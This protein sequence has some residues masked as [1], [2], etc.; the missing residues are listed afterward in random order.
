MPVVTRLVLPFSIFWLAFTWFICC[1]PRFGS[2][3]LIS[4]SPTFLWRGWPINGF[5]LG[6]RNVQICSLLNKRR[7]PLLKRHENIIYFGFSPSWVHLQFPKHTDY[8]FLSYVWSIMHLLVW[9]L[10]NLNWKQTNVK[11]KIIRLLFSFFV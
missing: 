1:L 3:P 9:L 4:F 11:Q 5:R 2:R 10:D 8:F 6:F 7:L